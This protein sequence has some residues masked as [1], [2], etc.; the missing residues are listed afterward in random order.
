MTNSGGAEFPCASQIRLSGST[1]CRRRAARPSDFRR[2]GKGR[3]RHSSVGVRPI[4][5]L[6]GTPGWEIGE[7]GGIR[8]DDRMVTSDPRIWA[9]GDAVEVRDFITGRWTLV[10]LAGRQIARGGSQR[11]LFMEGTEDFEG[12]QATAVCGFRPDDCIHRT[13][14]KTLKRLGCGA[15]TTTRF[16]STR[17]T[18]R[19]TIPAPKPSS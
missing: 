4:Q 12:F 5:N 11:T 7:L 1:R 16:T 9:V 3:Y 2:R 10:P 6:P 15:K 19:G 17:C 18:M 14:E 13:S 8:V